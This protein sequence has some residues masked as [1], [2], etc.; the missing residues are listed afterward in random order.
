MLYIQINPDEDTIEN[1]LKE[2]AKKA[3]IEY[4]PNDISPELID[5]VIPRILQRKDVKDDLYDVVFK[6]LTES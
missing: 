4:D 2:E 3:G 5:L 1:V 6:Y